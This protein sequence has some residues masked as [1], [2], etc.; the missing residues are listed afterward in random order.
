MRRTRARRRRRGRCSCGTTASSPPT[1]PPA[2]SR[3]CA[4]W[5]PGTMHSQRTGSGTTQELSPEFFR[6]RDKSTSNSLARV[7]GGALVALAT[8]ALAAP[9]SA[10]DLR[11][12]GLDGAV[13]TVRELVGDRPAVVAFW[14]SYCAPCKAEVPA[15]NRAAERW[16]PRGVRVIGV[17]LEA[18]VARVREAAKAWDAH[19]DVFPVVEGQ[20]KTTEALFP[21]GLPTSAF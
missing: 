12:V 9:P 11:V 5:R 10:L 14:A 4:R 3:A 2:S 13:T 21:N 6:R 16:G 15:L 1:C 7:A 8:A 17:S 18:D 19:Y 20:E